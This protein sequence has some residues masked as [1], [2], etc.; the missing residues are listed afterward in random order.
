[1]IA[2]IG[3]SANQARAGDLMLV[4]HVGASTLTI[5]ST[6]GPFTLPGSDEQHLL[7]DTAALNAALI[8][9]G[10]QITFA[11]LGAGSNWTGSSGPAGATLSQTDQ[12]QILT[13]TPGGITTV[14]VDAFLDGY[15][16]PS[17]TTGTLQHSGTA[18]FTN[19]ATGDSSSS[20]SNY[21]GT[22]TTPLPAPPGQVFTSTGLNLNS[23]SGDVS[24]GIPAFVTPFSL[25]NTVTISLTP[26]AAATVEDLATI[27]TKVN[28]SAIPEPTSIV[29]MLTSMPLPLIVLGMLRRRRRT[30]AAG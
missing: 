8:G 30:L 27:S 24:T 10:S 26:N 25:F 28:A 18:N 7:V 3:L 6:G 4:V 23:H 21:N 1:L 16:S 5:D 15:T 20:W 22:V 12:A 14:T 2:V 13:S 11:S 9:L 29:V 17:G 19:A